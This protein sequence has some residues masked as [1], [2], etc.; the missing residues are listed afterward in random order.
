[1]HFKVNVFR[2]FMSLR[3]RLSKCKDVLLTYVAFSTA[4]HPAVG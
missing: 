4:L 3:H 2:F 1:M